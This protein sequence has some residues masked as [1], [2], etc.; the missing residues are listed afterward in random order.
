MQNPYALW[1]K[2]AG[3]SGRVDWI[4]GVLAWWIIAIIPAVL[5]LMSVPAAIVIALSVVSGLVALVGVVNLHIRR[6]H[7]MGLSGW[8]VMLPIPIFMAESFCPIEDSVFAG[9]L[10][11]LCLFM[12]LMPPART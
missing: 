5:I 3:V 4:V 1:K 8:W 6:L 12:A 9:M 11:L 2:S 10:L 7:D